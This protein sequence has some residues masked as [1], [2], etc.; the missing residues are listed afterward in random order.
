[1]E[2]KSTHRSFGL[3]TRPSAR[4]AWKEVARGPSKGKVKGHMRKVA[5][6]HKMLG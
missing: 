4:A 6:Y 5:S 3:A 2:I 1:M